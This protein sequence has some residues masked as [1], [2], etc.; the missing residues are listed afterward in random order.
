MTSSSF[1]E[2]PMEIIFDTTFADCAKVSVSPRLIMLKTNRKLNNTL[3]LFFIF[4][5]FSPITI[6]FLTITQK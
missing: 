5:I 1:D 3:I 4:F 2:F 6:I